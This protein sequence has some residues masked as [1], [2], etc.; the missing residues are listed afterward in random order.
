ML[1]SQF[2]TDSLPS[3]RL[4]HTY[5]LV[6]VVLF[7]AA[8]AFVSIAPSLVAIAVVVAVAPGYLV[9]FFIASR[10]RRSGVPGHGTSRGTTFGASTPRAP[11]ARQLA[12]FLSVSQPGAQSQAVPPATHTATVCVPRFLLHRLSFCCYHPPLLQFDS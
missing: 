8:I 3:V 12:V 10:R 2:V 7:A 9:S 6:V 4:R 11:S 5:V 1:A